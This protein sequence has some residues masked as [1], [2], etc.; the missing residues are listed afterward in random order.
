VVRGTL[1][2]TRLLPPAGSIAN[3]AIQADAEIDETKLQHRHALHYSA[4]GTVVAATEYIH[5]MPVDGALLSIEAA[6]TEIIATG[7]DRTVNVDLQKS[8]GAGAFATVMTATIEFDNASVL[9]T[10]VAGVLASTALVAGDILKIVI[11]VAGAAGNQALGLV[12]TV[13]LREDGV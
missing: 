5:I 3:A 9:R 6:I 1:S 4:T 13:E 11:T 10:A 2:A 12:V 8:T 7:A